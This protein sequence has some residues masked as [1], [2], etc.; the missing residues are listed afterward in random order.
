MPVRHFERRVWMLAGGIA[1]P[2]VAVFIAWALK[3]DAPGWQRWT[4]GLACVVWPLVLVHVLRRWVRHPLSTLTNQIAGMREG[5]FTIRVRGAESPDALGQLVAELNAL[6]EHFREHRLEGVET[7]ALLR[8]VMEEIS[9]AVFAFD[10]QQRLQLV[11][12]AGEQL[13]GRSAAQMSGRRAGELGLEECL[14]GDPA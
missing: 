8:T 3:G 6:G 14:R 2:G 11:N 10:H 9:V 4:V 12:R 13:L 1:V 7:A 5:D